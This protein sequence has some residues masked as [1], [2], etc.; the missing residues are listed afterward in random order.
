MTTT[1]EA[2]GDIVDH[3]FP[4]LDEEPGDGTAQGDPRL[5]DLIWALS[6]SAGRIPLLP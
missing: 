4:E 2:V 1:A 3:V 6:L 5:A